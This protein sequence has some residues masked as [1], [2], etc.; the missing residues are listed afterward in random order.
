MGEAWTKRVYEA[1][2]NSPQWEN[3]LF[4][5]TFDEHGVCALCFY[6]SFC[7][8]DLVEIDVPRVSG[9]GLR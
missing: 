3:M 1:L 5:V 4:L 2:R 6:R 9:T 7:F 8:F